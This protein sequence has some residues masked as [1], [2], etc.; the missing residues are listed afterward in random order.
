M[1]DMFNV[2]WRD[3]VDDFGVIISTDFLLNDSS[4]S[5]GKFMYKIAVYVTRGSIMVQGNAYGQFCDKES[6]NA[7]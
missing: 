5:E 7:C 2:I 3:H 6:S 1:N 4:Q